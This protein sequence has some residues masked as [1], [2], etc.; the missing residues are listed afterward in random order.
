MKVYRV[1]PITRGSSWKIYGWKVE[2]E[3]WLGKSTIGKF[4]E[5][6]EA[7]D[8][9]KKIGDGNRPS[10]VKLLNNKGE[11]VSDWSYGARPR[12]RNISS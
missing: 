6:Q 7:I 10:E 4:S 5:R 9:V 2:K 3:G 1:A 8:Y 12:S 11:I